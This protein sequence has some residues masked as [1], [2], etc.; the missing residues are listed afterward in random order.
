VNGCPTEIA[1][2]LIKDITIQSVAVESEDIEAVL[3]AKE[4]LELQEYEN[5]NYLLAI[6]R[7]IN[8]EPQ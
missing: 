3:I 7:I 4:M 2:L 5:V 6:K 8:M 1:K